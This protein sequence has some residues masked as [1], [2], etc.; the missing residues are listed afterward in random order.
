MDILWKTIDNS[1]K[2]CKWIATFVCDRHIGVMG[3]RHQMT[4][5]TVWWRM[6][7]KFT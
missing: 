4:M 7:G 3:I 5:W 2:G 6:K 1:L